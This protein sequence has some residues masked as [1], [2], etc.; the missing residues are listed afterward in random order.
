METNPYAPPTAAVA[1]I[2]SP[3]LKR[4]SVILMIVF[5]LVSFGFYYPIWFMRRRA[6]FNQL[7]SP[8][9]LPLWPFVVALAWF[10]FAFGF[11]FVMGVV[12]ALEGS[13]GVLSQEERLFFSIVRLAVGVLM[14]FQCFR[15]KDILED[16]F[17]GPGDQVASPMFAD[18]YR[19]S[20][21]MTFFF[22]I[23]YLQYAINR[24]LAD[25]Q[26]APA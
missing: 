14:L 18:A 16:H 6:A 17:A 5:S 26:A 19:L 20:G 7:D 2:S 21:V 23:F 9:K 25:S 15:T 13:A 24:Y 12:R 11:G 8:R 22:Q 1:D 10:I 3:G 4:R